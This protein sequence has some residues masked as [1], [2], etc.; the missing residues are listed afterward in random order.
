[1]TRRRRWVRM[2]VWSS[3][4]H[5]FDHRCDNVQRRF[6]SLLVCRARGKARMEGKRREGGRRERGR[7]RERI[8]QK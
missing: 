3:Y 6:C 2:G 1:M 8:D 5:W 7:E 4:R